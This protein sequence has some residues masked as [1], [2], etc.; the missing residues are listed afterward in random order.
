MTCH[1]SGT[2]RER[3]SHGKQR[4]KR[5]VLRW[6]RKMAID[7]VDVTCCGRPF[8]IRGAATGKARS[9]MIDSRVRWTVSDDDEAERRRRWSSVSA[10]W[11]SSSARYDGATPADTCWRGEPVCRKSIVTG[12]HMFIKS[13]GAIVIRRQ[14][15][16]LWTPWYLGNYYISK[17]EFKIT[18]RYGKVPA[19]DTKI[20]ILYDTTWGR[21]PGWFSTNV[22]ISEADY[23]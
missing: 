17:V 11:Q 18:I 9:L 3:W 19:L 6:L 7:G 4:L 16:N 13:L 23:G 14:L 15:N 2:T 21:P 12:W 1:F 10:G 22:Y 20:I 8:Q 5:W